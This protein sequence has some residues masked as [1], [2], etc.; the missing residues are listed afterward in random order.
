MQGTRE[1][2]FSGVDPSGAF[3]GTGKSRG[4]SQFPTRI[5]GHPE[6]NIQ[7]TAGKTGSGFERVFPK[8]KT[9]THSHSD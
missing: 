5:I 2:E 7:Q 1:G 4:H 6:R 8:G 9:G 3:N